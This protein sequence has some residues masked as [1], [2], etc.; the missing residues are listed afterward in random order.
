MIEVF[1]ILREIYVKAVSEG[2]LH[3]AQGRRTSRHSLKLVTQHCR[4]E[5]RRNCFSVPGVKPWN[6]LPE[7]VVS[8][9]TVQ[10]FESCRLDKVWSNQPVRFCYKEEL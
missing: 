3:L 7:F 4:M 8:S 5:I 10:M 2:I 1:K 9:T 6:L